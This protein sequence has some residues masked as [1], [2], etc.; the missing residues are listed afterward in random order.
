MDYKSSGVDIDAGNDFV[1]KIKPFVKSTLN[2]NVPGNIGGFAGFYDIAETV[3]KIKNPLLCSSTDGVGTKLKVAI[4][5]GKFDTVGIDL[6]AMCVNDLIVPGAK[7]LFF[8]DYLATSKLNIENMSEVV[9]GI[10]AGC[11]EADVALLGGETAEMPG[12]YSDKDFD[13]AG[14]AVGIVDK[15]KIIDGSDIKESDIVFGLPS[16]GFHS[17]G[18]SLLRKLIKESGYTFEDEF[19]KGTSIGEMLLE[20]TKIY[21][22]D[23]MEILNSG[24]NIKGMA[25]ITG[26]GFYENIPRILPPGTGAD[27]YRDKIPQMQCYEFIKKL[28]SGEE[29]ELYRVLNMGIGMVMVVD[30]AD[31][32]SFKQFLK[33]NLISA[34]EIGKITANKEVR[35][36]GVDF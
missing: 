32:E 20:P 25:H 24:I 2:A 30:Y 7:P 28:Y 16:T 21:V 11:R 15:E 18:Y 19:V 14:F 34:Y 13:L 26:G 22:K 35:I 6:V 4:E 8:L 5:T 10:A 29:R 23:V 1:N 9:K 27:I 12:M 3:G 31:Y 36:S 33:K 17:N